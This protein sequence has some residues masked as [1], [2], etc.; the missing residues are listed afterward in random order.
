MLGLILAVILFNLVAFITNNR[1]TKN[2]I[3]H[4]WTFTTDFQILG[5]TY[6]DTKYHGY[7]YFTKE[8]DGWIEITTF[9]VL[10]PPVNMMF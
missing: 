6:I 8:I 5:D 1:L 7:W 3:V 4:I 2:Q 10:I 9:T